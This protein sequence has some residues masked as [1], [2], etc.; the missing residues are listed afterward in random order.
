VYLVIGSFRET[1]KATLSWSRNLY[2]KHFALTEILEV[3]IDLWELKKSRQRHSLWK[4]TAFPL[5][6][7]SAK[8]FTRHL[9]P[10]IAQFSICSYGTRCRLPSF[11]FIFLWLDYWHFG[12]ALLP[13]MCWPFLFGVLPMSDM[14]WQ[15]KAKICLL[16]AEK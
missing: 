15:V 3:L 9:H 2:Q 11:F 6:F 16:S 13:K 8:L 14:S 1:F 10:W 12:R 4:F 5:E 7:R